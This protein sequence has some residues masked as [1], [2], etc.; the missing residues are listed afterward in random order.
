MAAAK[1]LDRSRPSSA[2]ARLAIVKR[3]SAQT[4]AMT[5]VAVG[6]METRHVWFRELD[7]EHRSW[8][9]LVARAGIDGFVTW[10]ADP[11]PA[12]LATS[13]VFGSAP[14]ELARR[15]SLHQTVELV[16]TTID[17]VETQIEEVMPRADRPVLLT[18]IVAYRREV[19]FAAAEIYAQAA[20]L[21]GTWDARL[22]TSVV[23]AV[24]WV[25]TAQAAATDDLAHTVDY[26][27]VAQD[28][29]G[30]I[31]GSVMWKNCCT[32]PA[33]SMVAAS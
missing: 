4:A 10:F 15:I 21:S 29:V 19:A 6:E 18:A 31:E 28:I 27:A 33:P 16:R 25:S 11:D 13:D 26:G 23:D 8:I 5:T 32:R 24:L 9:T 20:E 30:L 3:L 17:V 22:E 7:A 12:G 1:G 14:R 2:K